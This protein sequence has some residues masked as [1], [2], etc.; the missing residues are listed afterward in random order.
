MGR[1]GR[2][3]LF[4]CRRGSRP[5]FFISFV[6]KHLMKLVMSDTFAVSWV[7]ARLPSGRHCLLSTGVN[8]PVSDALYKNSALLKH[9][10]AVFAATVTFYVAEN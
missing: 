9:V 1:P 4:V 6:F 3:M 2:V 8:G 7:F 10:T 5:V